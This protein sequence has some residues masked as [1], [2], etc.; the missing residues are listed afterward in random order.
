MAN[1]QYMQEL[2]QRMGR[3]IT[4]TIIMGEEALLGFGMNLERIR[5]LVGD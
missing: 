1:P 4:P 3:F 2:R 5:E